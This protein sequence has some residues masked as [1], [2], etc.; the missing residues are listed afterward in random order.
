ME[1]FL[2]WLDR[3][4]GRLVPNG[5]PLYLIGLW[6]LA[7]ILLFLK[8]ELRGDFTLT[9]FGLFHGEAW[10]LVTFLMLPPISG[11]D[12]MALL[13]AFFVF[14]FAYLVVGSLEDQWGALR[15]WVYLAIGAA[16]T[17]GAA[18]LVGAA[19]NQ[20]L[21]ASLILA[22]ATEFPDYQIMLFLILPVKMKWLGWFTAAGLVWVVITGGPIARAAILVAFANYLLFFAARLYALARGRARELGPRGAKAR[23]SAFQQ[24][25]ARPE[26]RARVCAKCGKSEA[27]DPTLEFRVCTCEKCGGRPTEYCLEHARNH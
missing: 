11:R 15:L 4:F 3:R 27:D 13:W 22:F 26:R 5:L 17:V 16:G 23:M 24:H 14:Q 2:D 7:F 19:D 1:R 18:L 6:G 25:T 20:W 9:R 21:Y 8:P 12:A 10:R